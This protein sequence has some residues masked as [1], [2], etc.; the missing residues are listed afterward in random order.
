[1]AQAAGA[2]RLALVHQS[3]GLNEP[4]QAERALRDIT[5]AYDGEVVWGRELM[6]FEV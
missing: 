1:L 3:H 6:S 4:G 2:K 5:A